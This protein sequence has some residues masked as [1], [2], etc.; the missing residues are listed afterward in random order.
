MYNF[1][2]SLLFRLDP[3]ASHGLAL[4]ALDTLHRVG[5]VQR[6]Y[7]EPVSDPV[8]LMGLRFSNR[9]GLAAGLDKNA[10]HL[11][12]LG[13]LGFGFV[14]VGTVTPKAQPGNPKPRLFRLAGH[15]AIIN[16]FG[17]NNKGVE[18]LVAQVKKRHYGGVVGINIGKNL[19]TSV[20][21]AL[22]DYLLCLEAVHGVADYIAVN[23]SSPNTPGL[24]TLQFGEQLDALLGP[25]RSRSQ[26]LDNAL[27][28]K[29]PLL[30]KIAP[31]MS[32]EEVV[33]VAD[34]IAR[35]ALDGVIATNTTIARDAV[36]SDPQ[37][38]EAGGLSGKP[39]FEASNRVIRLLRAQLPTLPIIGVGGIDSG[40]AA[41]AKI[42]AGADLVQLYSGLIYQ[43]PGLV[44]ACA[45]ALK[46]Q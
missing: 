18:H 45:E 31:D 15:E 1:A 19:T 20:E 10:D 30:V 32:E 27:G 17:F 43:G 25:I 16:R 40:E 41:V 44:K 46:Q 3:E 24:R 13:A 26:A 39:V 21:N 2:R 7:G 9:V 12:A 28:R 35:N 42:A 37:S 22:D 4:G 34:S 29:V 14:E 8:E 6:V 38:E 5:G 11:D 36:K 23:I 33:L